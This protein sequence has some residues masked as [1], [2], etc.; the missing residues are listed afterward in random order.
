[1]MAYSNSKFETYLLDQVFEME[2]E[3]TVKCLTKEANDLFNRNQ[4]PEGFFSEL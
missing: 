3:E 1:M 2:E 4:Y